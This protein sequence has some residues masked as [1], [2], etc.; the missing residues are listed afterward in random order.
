MEIKTAEE[1][2]DFV[3]FLKQPDAAELFAKLDYLLK[4]GMHIQNQLHPQY[5]A[6]LKKHEPHIKQYYK[7]IYDVKLEVG[8]DEP[9]RYYYLDFI[10][11]SR[12][13]VPQEQRY[14]LKSEHVI[15]GFMIYK[16]IYIDGNVTLTSIKNLQKTIRNDHEEL[17]PGIYRV[18]AKSRNE[19]PG[20]LN[21]DVVDNIIEQALREFAKIGWIAIKE[22]DFE[23][24]PAFQ[25]IT[26][27]YDD[28]INNI[29][30]FFAETE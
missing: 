11:E 27:I 6:Y 10:G 16:I 12:G 17:K 15:I 30:A 18:L 5:Y 29:D 8:G 23:P 24:L 19:K 21:D 4:D 20:N 7:T 3:N 28:I 9:Q 13:N 22:D 25:R 2:T 26:K 14:Y 1:K